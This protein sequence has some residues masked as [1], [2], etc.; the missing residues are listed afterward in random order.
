MFPLYVHINKP[1][2]ITISPQEHIRTLF[3]PSFLSIPLARTSFAFASTVLRLLPARS[4]AEGSLGKS[5]QNPIRFDSVVLSSESSRGSVKCYLDCTHNDYYLSIRITKLDLQGN[6]PTFT[7]SEYSTLMVD[8]TLES[9]NFPAISIYKPGDA[10]VLAK[11]TCN[12]S[13]AFVDTV[14]RTSTPGRKLM[15]GF[16]SGSVG[17]ISSFEITVTPYYLGT[18]YSCPA[19]HF[20]C[21]NTKDHCIPDSITCDGVDN[22]FDNSDE[23][24][25]LCTGRI[26]N[27]PL[28]LFIILIIV[29]ILFLLALI[30]G[31]AIYLRRR[32]LRKQNNKPEIAEEFKA[33]FFPTS[34]FSSRMDGS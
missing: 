20:R 22:C 3:V 7:I 26:G 33:L 6:C 12:D 8:E 2:N 17:K 19:D 4:F 32:H 13:A 24:N 14:I 27:L 25:Y 5:P 1:V 29:G 34:T 11:A 30:T 9:A 15:V 10:N 21:F 18:S 16:D 28:P 23:S 31:V